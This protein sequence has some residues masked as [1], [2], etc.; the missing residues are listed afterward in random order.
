MKEHIKYDPTTELV[1]AELQN[2]RK[3]KRF[4]T[5]KEV[6]DFFCV[7]VKTVRKWIHRGHL[8]AIMTDREWKIPR[9]SVIEFARERSNFRV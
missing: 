7:S 9:A 8:S 2:F 4:L 1:E 5:V 6:A 3:L